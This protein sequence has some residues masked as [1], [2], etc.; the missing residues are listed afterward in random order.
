V[1]VRKLRGFSRFEWE[2]RADRL[3]GHLAMAAIRVCRGH[4]LPLPRWAR[5]V[6]VTTVCTLA[7]EH[8]RARHV[9][10][11]E[12]VLF[13]ATSGEG[14]DEPVAE[15]YADPALGWAGRSAKGVRSIDVPGGHLSMLQEP[16]VAVLAQ[17]LTASLGTAP[18]GRR[19]G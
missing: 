2:R 19:A 9:V 3:R 11:D 10:R 16:H 8:Y 13:R 18:G 14:Q 4:G 1:L 15:V 17:R 5:R 6:P 7:A 12:I